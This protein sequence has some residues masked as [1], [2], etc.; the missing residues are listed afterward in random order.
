MIDE[1]TP[2]RMRKPF[3][4]YQFTDCE[5]TN[6]FR[7]QFEQTVAALFNGFKIKKH[8]HKTA[9]IKNFQH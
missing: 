4:G 8:Q 2:I 1:S 5:L 6:A 7:I 9:V 3:K